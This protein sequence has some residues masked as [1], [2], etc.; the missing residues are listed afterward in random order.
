VQSLRNDGNSD[1]RAGE[2]NEGKSKEREMVEKKSDS[3]ESRVAKCV[4]SPDKGM[5]SRSAIIKSGIFPLS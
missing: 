4:S 5:N 2:G 1:R 3:F